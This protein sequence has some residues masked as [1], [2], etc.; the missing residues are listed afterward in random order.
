MRKNLAICTVIAVV[1]LIAAYAYFSSYA[2]TGKYQSQPVS[3]VI[4]VTYAQTGAGLPYFVAEDMGYFKQENLTVEAAGV[5]TLSSVTSSLLANKADAGIPV[6]FSD[7]IVTE[8]KQPGQFRA[9]A[10]G[11]ETHDTNATGIMVMPNSTYRSIADLKGKRIGIGSGLNPLVVGRWKLGKYFNASNVTFVTMSSS[12]ALAGAMASNQVDA[13]VISQP[14]MASAVKKGLARDLPNSTDAAIMDPFVVNDYVLTSKFVAQNPRTAA[15]FVNAMDE[16][17][18]Y[19]NTNPQGAMQILAA[20]T[21]T[22]VEQLKSGDNKPPWRDTVLVN[23]T[24]KDS[25]VNTSA[26]AAMQAL[27]NKYFAANFINDT[28]NVSNIVYT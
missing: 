7:I 21:N 5:S 4:R 17:V 25:E 6:S 12:F 24:F 23:G 15:K 8:A 1:L 19:I 22:T 2:Q 28:V 10:V 9:F 16:A 13:I 3:N 18:A 11:A 27:A 14:A 20:H 26:M